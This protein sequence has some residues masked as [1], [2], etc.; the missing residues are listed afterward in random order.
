MPLFQ[1]SPIRRR[2]PHSIEGKINGFLIPS[3]QGNQ[4][5]ML[6]I[7]AV[8]LC[9]LLAF[10]SVYAKGGKGGGP[11]YGGGKHT[12]GHGGKY[13]GGKGSSHKDGSYKNNK[14]DDQY[15]KHK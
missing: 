7:V 15:G 8:I 3:P 9:S 2:R 10:G 12:S 5:N 1:F 6:R 11:K 14:T 4:M 13:Q